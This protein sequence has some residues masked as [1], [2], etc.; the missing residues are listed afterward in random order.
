MNLQSTWNKFLDQP[1]AL[2][3]ISLAA[4]VLMSPIFLPAIVVAV[5]VYGLY[6]SLRLVGTPAGLI[7]A[8]AVL[9]IPFVVLNVSA[10]ERA[11]LVASVAQGAS[12]NATF[13]QISTSASPGAAPW[14]GW[15]GCSV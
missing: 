2:I 6:A 11:M 9:A 15:T 1:D 8:H 5:A 14:R 12:Y 13:T 4:L 7:A 10:A 3:K